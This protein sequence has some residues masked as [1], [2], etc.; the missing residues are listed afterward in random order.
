MGRYRAV[1]I[2][3]IAVAVSMGQQATSPAPKQ[4]ASPRAKYVPPSKPRSEA[5]YGRLYKEI[6]ECDSQAAI[7]ADYYF[8]ETP[9][10]E[11]PSPKEQRAYREKDAARADKWQSFYNKELTRLY[12]LVALQERISIEEVEDIRAEGDIRG[13]HIDPGRRDR[14]HKTEK[15]IQEELA[16]MRMAM[17]AD[18]KADRE[19]EAKEVEARAE[20]EKQ[21]IRNLFQQAQALEKINPKAAMQYYRDIRDDYPGTPEASKAKQRL[22]AMEKGQSTKGAKAGAPR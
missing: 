21:R 9:P 5:V 6:K 18:R 7:R 15:Q 2:G 20:K 8:P 12:G 17:E 4:K 3:L 1:V 13:W 14:F 11:N 22:E 10:P 19:R 16:G